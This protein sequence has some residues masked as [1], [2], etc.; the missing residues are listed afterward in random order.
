MLGTHFAKKRLEQE[1]A[2]RQRSTAVFLL[3]MINSV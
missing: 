3:Y 2:N 1:K